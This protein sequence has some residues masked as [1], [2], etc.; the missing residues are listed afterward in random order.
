[1][2]KCTQLLA[3]VSART[4]ESWW[5]PWEIGIATEKDY[6]LATYAGDD[7]YL[8]EYLRKWP[9]LSTM[10]ELDEYARISKFAERQLSFRKSYLTE[11]EARRNSTREFFT[12]LR[13]SLGQ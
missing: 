10:S 1:M 2:G 6:L 8:P 3:V 9:Y 5:V 4:R 11:S 7:T 12:K 13:A